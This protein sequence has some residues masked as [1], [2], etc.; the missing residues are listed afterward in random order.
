MLFL[1][2]LREQS[3]WFLDRLKGKSIKNHFEDIKYIQE[4]PLS[5]FSI[6]KQQQYLNNILKHA[7]LTTNYYSKFKRFKSINDFPIIKKNVVQDQFND[8]KSHKFVGSETYKVSTSGS[9][10]TPFFLYHDANKKKRNKAETIYFLNQVGY[11]IG[12]PL[13][14][15]RL[16]SGETKSRFKSI[17]QNVIKINVTNLSD[18]DLHHILNRIKSDKARKTFLGIASSFEALCR[19]LDKIKSPPI[20]IQ[21]DAFIANS[22]ALSPY[23]KKAIYHYFN[24]PIVSRYSNEEQGIIS[25]QKIKDNSPFYIN[26][27]SYFV[28]I[29]KLNSDL[30]AKH[31]E[32]GR[33]VVT[34][35]FNYCMPLIR[36]DTE[37]LGVMDYDEKGE[38]VLTRV[39]G[40]KMDAIYTTN[41]DLISS[42]S[43]Y[44]VFQPFY[45]KL[46]QYQFIQVNEF[47]YLIKINSVIE[48]SIEDERFIKTELQNILGNNSEISFRYVNEIPLLASGKRKKVIS[49]YKKSK[50]TP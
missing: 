19:Y 26:K 4:N 7:S 8:F 45:K 47:T 49:F 37:D 33:I 40:R 32:I 22:E 15:F 44:P 39:E 35:L 2:F 28:E 29:C 10:G 41:G 5:E 23:T 16:W 21:A 17:L 1:I 50:I 31:G 3:F 34:D 36:Y 11:N 6:S 12:T 38:L 9:T 24:T 46:K 20:D 18:K 27:A 25:Q 14:Y 42:Y 43:I 13:Y 48:F 30:P